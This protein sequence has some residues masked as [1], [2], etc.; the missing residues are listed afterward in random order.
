MF[1]NLL[2]ALLSLTLAA[3]TPAEAALTLLGVGPES[4][5]ASFPS[6][7]SAATSARG[8]SL[9]ASTTIVLPATINA[10]DLILV[11]IS[12]NTNAAIT[13]SATGYSSLISD[14]TS[15]SSFGV[16]FKSAAGTEGGT[17]LTINLSASGRTAQVAMDI[18]GWGG[19]TPGQAEAIGASGAPNPPSLTP[20]GGAANFLWIAI[21]QNKDTSNTLTSDPTN[22][23]LGV[24]DSG[25][26]G[27]GSTG[28][29][30]IAAAARQLNAATEDPGTFT[31]L[32][33]TTAWS[34][35]TISVHP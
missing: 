2:A 9:A 6:I 28:T 7:G 19:A 17:T 5:A 27:S 29:P 34:A 1:R 21:G 14:T 8:T 25:N 18:R 4:S 31:F 13:F 32:A 26:S 33:T 16:L 12:S 11:A 30:L 10:G 24:I 15:G 22:Y 35:A 23:N 3:A 20:A